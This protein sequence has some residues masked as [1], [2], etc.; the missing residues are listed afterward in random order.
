MFSNSVEVARI[1]KRWIELDRVARRVRNDPQRKLYC[2]RALAPV[3]D[4]ETETLDLFT[5]N[6]GARGEVVRINKITALTRGA[7]APAEP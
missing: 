5:H 7:A 3:T 6:A 4:D 2:D 1:A